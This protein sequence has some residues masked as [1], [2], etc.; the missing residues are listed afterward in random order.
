MT[1]RLA[2]RINLAVDAA[3][4]V[5]GGDLTAEL[6][7]RGLPGRDRRAAAFHWQDDREPEQPRR[8]RQAGQ[9]STEFDGDGAIGHQPPA[10]GDRQF[11]RRFGQSDRRGD[12]TDFGHEC[13]IAGHDARGEPR[14]HRYGR[15]G[16]GQPFQSAGHGRQH[17]RP[18]PGHRFDRRE[19]GRHQREGV[20]HHGHRDHDQQGRRSDESAVGQCRHRSGEGGRVRRWVSGRGPRDPPTGRSDGDRDAGHRTDGAADA[21]GRVGRRDGNGPLYRP[22]PPQRPG[23][24]HDQPADGRDHRAGQRQHEPV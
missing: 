2:R 18:G 14:G 7:S 17:A 15:N 20:E 23:R 16:H 21:V 1:F 10:G 11:V 24:G 3:E 6:S 19:A 9:H 13:G 4:R 22:G 12:Q 8:Q 5:A